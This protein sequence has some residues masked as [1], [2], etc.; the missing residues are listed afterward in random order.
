MER[1][2]FKSILHNVMV[3]LVGFCIA[4]I[5]AKLDR[6]L[7][8]HGF[9]SVF[10]T[11]AGWLL[12]IA[13]FLLR[14]WAAFYFYAHRLKVISL[15]PQKVLFTSGPY[16]FSRNPLYLGGN[17]FVFFGAALFMGS[18]MGVLITVFHLPLVDLFIRREERQLEKEFGD[19]WI[20]Y[21]NRVRRWI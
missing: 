20:R 21:K 10:A 15:Q 13:G 17:V 6:L 8:I 18:P 5:G 19:D 12:L 16:R 7:G 2:L 9:H 11:L 4:F 14:V 3:V 1:Y